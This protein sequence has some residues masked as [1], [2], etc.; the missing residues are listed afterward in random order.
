MTNTSGL[1]C[2]K[3]NDINSQPCL[4]LSFIL[5][6]IFIIELRYIDVF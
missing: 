6:K 4:C 5:Y 1:A 3:E 2:E